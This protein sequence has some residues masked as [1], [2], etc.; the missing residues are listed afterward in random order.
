MSCYG[1]VYLATIYYQTY[2]GM[3]ALQAAIRLLPC[4]VV[5]TVAAV[6]HF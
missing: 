4:T 1:Y 6:C 5:G 3:T 2:M